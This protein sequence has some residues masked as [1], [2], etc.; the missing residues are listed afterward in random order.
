MEKKYHALRCLKNLTKG[1]DSMPELSDEYWM[2]HALVLAQ[3]A[4]ELGEVPVGAC[5]VRED[6][7]IGE[8]WNQPITQRDPSAHAEILALRAA[9]LTAQNY[10]LPDATLYVTIEPCTMCL[11]A[12]IHARIARVV[13]GALEPKAGVLQSHP[14]LIQKGIYNHSVSWTG[15]VLEN[16]CSSIIQQFF[17]MRRAQKKVSKE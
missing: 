2:R 15:G 13:F 11:G 1:C 14:E 4:Y 12:L 16:E 5:L 6:R 8:G 3:R 9:G 17:Q 10:R 7:L